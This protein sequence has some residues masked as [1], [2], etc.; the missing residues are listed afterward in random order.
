MCLN[1]LVVGLGDVFDVVCMV[2]LGGVLVDCGGYC[3]GVGDMEILLDGGVQVVVGKQQCVGWVGEVDVVWCFGEND[4][5]GE[6][7]VWFV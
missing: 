3:V 6:M 5:L 1:C 2:E 7:F 4:W